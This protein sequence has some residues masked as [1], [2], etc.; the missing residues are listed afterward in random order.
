MSDLENDVATVA[1]T[2]SKKIKNSADSKKLFECANTS[3]GNQLLFGA[4]FFTD[5]LIPRMNY[6]PW[7]VVNNKHTD[8]IQ[9]Q[10][11]YHL[12]ELICKEYKVN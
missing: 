1:E 6:I 5:Q 11:E 7:I 2:C 8:T 4:G 10:A 12:N 9:N 3:L